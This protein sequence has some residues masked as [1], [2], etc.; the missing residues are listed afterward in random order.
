MGK[1]KQVVELIL[2]RL[3]TSRVIIAGDFNDARD[4]I[5]RYLST[6]GIAPH[7]QEELPTNNRGG[8]LDQVF[9]N[10]TCDAVW[11]A[12]ADFTDHVVVSATFRIQR[13]AVGVNITDLPRRVTQA[14]MR[15]NAVSKDTIE[16]MLSLEDSI[17]QEAYKLYSDKCR[18]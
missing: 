16:R 12:D 14:E 4:E 2:W 9:S 13:T 3:P 6:K 11:V 1:I 8:H 7:L 17:S 18:P 15:R 10:M 5:A